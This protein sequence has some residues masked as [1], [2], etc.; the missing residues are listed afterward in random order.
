VI[1]DSDD[2]ALV[3]PTYEG[4]PFLRRTLDHLKSIAYPG[5][6]VISDDSS[7]EHRAFAA[8]APEAYPELWLEV[9]AYP[10]GT[11]FLPKLCATLERVPARYVMLCAQ[12]DFVVPEA[13]EQL[14]AALDADDTLAA[15]RGRVA[16][17]S[18]A[19]SPDGGAARVELHRHPMRE[20]LDADPARRV[21][22]MVRD[23]APALYSV[24]RRSRFLAA[25]ATAEAR[26]PNVIFFQYL[27]SCVTARQGGIGCLD[28]LY[29]VRQGHARS[30]AATLQRDY[31]HWPLLIASPDYSRH[32]GAFRAAMLDLLARDDG[33]SAVT[34]EA[35]DEAYVEL[36]RRSLCG[37]GKPN[38]REDAF[39]ARLSDRATPEG[40]TLAGVVDFCLRYPETW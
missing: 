36:A 39:F 11:R 3:M 4:T 9:H 1:E 31:E 16:R 33:T 38:P 5:L 26:A 32:F 23:F 30:W 12:D 22:D 28:L 13:L 6:V 15:I 8:A 37:A 10:H 27:A 14:V 7:G 25:L 20:Y 35:F 19:R 2:F 29:Y 34:G 18:L 40:R 24:H 17:F 21:L